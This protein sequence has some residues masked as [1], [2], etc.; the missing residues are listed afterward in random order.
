MPRGTVTWVHD[1][2]DQI[3]DPQLRTAAAAALA[4]LLQKYSYL[5]PRGRVL[6][7]DHG[8]FVNHSCAPN[9]RS[10]G[11]DLEIAVRDIHAGEELTDD[12]GSLN[13]DYEFDVPLRIAARAAARSAPPTSCA[14]PTTG[15]GRPVT[16]SAGADRQPAALAAVQGAD[17]DRTR[18]PRRDPVPSCRV[19]ALPAS[20]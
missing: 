2:L 9:C 16:P 17:G 20:L 18:G 15:T 11:F 7:W 13:V 12:Y 5:E 14:T 8:R 4:A 6:C 1:E 19:H 10:T 3:V